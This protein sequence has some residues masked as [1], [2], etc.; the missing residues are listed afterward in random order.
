MRLVERYIFRRMIIAMVLS[1]IALASMLWLS[2]ALRQFNLVTEQGQALST[3]FQLSAYLFP[4]LIMIVLPL[5]VLI[6][7]TF[8][9]T[10]LNADSE[11]A[12]INA[13]GMRQWSL[14]KPALVIGLIAAGLIGSMT[15]YFTPLSLRLGQT[16]LTHFE[17]AGPRNVLASY[18]SNLQPMMRA[19]LTERGTG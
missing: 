18:N 12:V 19:F 6:G 16:L 7:V 3:F 4:V 8:A 9:M 10:T 14:L 13:S 1:F 5:S 2:Q 17:I 15:L 11:L